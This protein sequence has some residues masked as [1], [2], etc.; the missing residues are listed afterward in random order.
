MTVKTITAGSTNLHATN[1]VNA[2]HKLAAESLP[3]IVVDN[4]CHIVF[5]KRTSLDSSEFI[6]FG[7]RAGFLFGEFL[8]IVLS[9]LFD[10]VAT[11]VFERICSDLVRARIDRGLF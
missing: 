2:A 11:F 8:E 5:F 9:Q 1:K 10:I 4:V 7:K 6:F 3:S